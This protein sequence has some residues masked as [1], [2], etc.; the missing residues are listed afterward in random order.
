MQKNLG[1][2]SGPAVMQ[3]GRGRVTLYCTVL[4]CTVL[5]AVMQLGRGRV[6]LYR[7]VPILF[8]VLAA[9]AWA[10]HLGLLAVIICLIFQS[11][12]NFVRFSSVFAHFVSPSKCEYVETRLCPAALLHSPGEQQ[13]HHSFMQIC[14]K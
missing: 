5:Y 6:A 2:G 10:F 11:V 12:E 3:L 8:A 1:R 13:A 9:T 14:K 7:D 4:Y